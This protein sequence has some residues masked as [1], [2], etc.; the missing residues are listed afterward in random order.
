M[1]CG[2]PDQCSWAKLGQ[3]KGTDTLINILQTHPIP[4][5]LPPVGSLHPTLQGKSLKLLR[6]GQGRI[7]SRLD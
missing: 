2:I 4:A 3:G 6:K 1:E 7:S 5:L